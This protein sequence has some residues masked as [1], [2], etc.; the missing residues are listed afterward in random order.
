MPGGDIEAIEGFG[1]VFDPAASPQAYLGPMTCHDVAYLLRLRA[2]SAGRPAGRPAK[3]VFAGLPA[4]TA[5][6]KRKL[7]RKP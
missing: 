4:E 2:N 5:P 7:P 6:R 3:R 1:R